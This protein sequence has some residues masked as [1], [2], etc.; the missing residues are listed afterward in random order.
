MAV[1]DEELRKLAELARDLRS[2]IEFPPPITR[3][4]SQSSVPTNN[5]PP[6]VIYAENCAGD[7]SKALTAAIDG[8]E[9]YLRCAP[10]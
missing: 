2:R 8:V 7:L 4:G 6:A 9:E 1:T 10:R 5:R 3:G